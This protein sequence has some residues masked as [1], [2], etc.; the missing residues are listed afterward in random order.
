M[1]E[2][3]AAENRLRE[4]HAILSEMRAALGGFDAGTRAVMGAQLRGVRGVLATLIEVD[5]AW[6]RAIEAALGQDTLREAIVVESASIVPEVRD[7]LAG[8]DGRVSLLPLEA[9]PEARSSLRPTTIR[10]ICR[11]MRGAACPS[12]RG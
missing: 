2:A 3:R 1:D 11:R 12:D 7:L 4:R 8:T 6:E 5:P 9:A 10:S